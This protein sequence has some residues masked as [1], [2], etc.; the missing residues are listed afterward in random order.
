LGSP[1]LDR[2]DGSA[3][4]CNFVGRKVSQ[5]AEVPAACPYWIWCYEEDSQAG[6]DMNVVMT[7]AG[8]F[9]EVHAAAE[10][11]PFD[12]AQMGT[13]IGLARAG[14]GRLIEVQKRVARW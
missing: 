3:F 14:I 12:D 10:H 8:G 13:L 9:I 2:G 11:T 4:R 1:G 7:G 5:A 6:V